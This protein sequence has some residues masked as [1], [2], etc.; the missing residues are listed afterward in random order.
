[1]ADLA[2]DTGRGELVRLEGRLAKS[3]SFWVKSVDIV[4]SYDR[5]DG[6]VVP[7]ALDV[8]ATLRLLGPATLHMTYAYSEIKGR[9]VPP[10]LIAR[11]Q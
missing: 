10:V 2:A 8:S 5:I 7:V 3:P 1:M 4:R 6:V 11:G 9:P